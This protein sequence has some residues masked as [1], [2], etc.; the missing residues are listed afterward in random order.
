MRH[1]AY[2]ARGLTHLIEV[3]RALDCRLALALPD[4]R[5]VVALHRGLCVQPLS[6]QHAR[7]SPVVVPVHLDAHA[8]GPL[9]GNKPLIRLIALKL[10]VEAHPYLR[11]ILADRRNQDVPTSLADRLCFFAPAHIHAFKR[12][13][14]FRRLIAQAAEVERR[15][16]LPAYLG[17][18]NLVERGQ[19]QRLDLILQQL[20]HRLLDALLHLSRAKH[21][22]RLVAAHDEQC[23]CEAPRL[24]GASPASCAL[25]ARRLEQE[26]QLLGEPGFDLSQT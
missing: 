6:L 4:V 12:L 16:V 22:Q 15:P 13:Q 11:A 3:D 23:A 10:R 18:Q 24:A 26:P 25:D 17:G 9:L 14:A 8:V 2:A 5:I 19:A 20:V 7:E 1:G 21:S